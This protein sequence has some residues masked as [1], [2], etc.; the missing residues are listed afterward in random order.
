M[1]GRNRPT[2]PFLGLLLLAGAIASPVA[3][4]ETSTARVRLTTDQLDLVFDLD[5]ASPV[6]WR[7]CH[8]S[9]AQADG[10]SGA[11]VRFTGADDP[12]QARLSLRGPGPAVDLQR[13]RFTAVVTE[14]ARARRVTFQSD[15]PGARV[16]LV[17]SFEVPKESGP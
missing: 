3:A 7:A 15:L 9:C 11:T 13:L 6:A 17:K 5:G 8:P 4:G 10:A 16:R 2:G 12:P 14:E 1:A